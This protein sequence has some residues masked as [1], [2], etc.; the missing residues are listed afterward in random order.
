M[1]C[2]KEEPGISIAAPKCQGRLLHPVLT[3]AVDLQAVRKLWFLHA[4]MILFIRLQ[5]IIMSEGAIT[6]TLALPCGVDQCCHRAP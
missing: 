3:F 5:L 2:L 6:G 1:V 4:L